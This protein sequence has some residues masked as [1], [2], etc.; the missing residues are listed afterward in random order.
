MKMVSISPAKLAS[1]IYPV[2]RVALAFLVIPALLAAA[3]A[4]PGVR[5]VLAAPLAGNPNGDLEIKP[6]TA[7]NFVVDSNVL[8]P[9]TYAPRSATL[10]AKFC[11]NGS[12]ALTDVVAYIGNYNGGTSSTPGI[13]P[14]RDSS[15]FGGEHDH[16][17]NTGDYFLIH[18][19]GSAGT[20]DATRYIGDLAAGECKTQYWLV[21]YPRKANGVAPDYT[22]DEGN[23]SVT[24]GS[25]KPD[26]DLWLNYDFWA[27]ADDGGSPLKADE[28]IKVTMRNEISAMA[29]KIWPNGDNKVPQ[30]YLDAITDAFGWDTI[31]PS[32]TGNAYPGETVT[33]QG[34]WYDFGVVGFGFDND[35]DLIPDHNAW[36]QPIGDPSSYDPGCFRLVRTYGIVVV[37]RQDGTET[38]IPFEDDLYFENVPDNTG[39]VGLVYYE[40]RALDGACTAGLTPYQEVASGY[41][42]E[43]F[44]GDFGAGIPPLQSQESEVTFDKNGDVTVDENNPITYTL[45]YTNVDPDGAGSMT[46]T[47]GDPDVGLGFTVFE[48]IPDGTYYVLDSADDALVPAG[49]YTIFYSTD[50]DPSDGITWS[51]TQSTGSPNPTTYIKWVRNSEV[52]NGESGS[53]QFQVTVPTGYTATNNTP[54]IENTACIKLGDADCFKED[55]HTTYVNGPNSLSGTVFKDDAGTTGVLANGLQ[56]GDEAGIFGTDGVTVTLYIDTD[57]DDEGDIL[58]GT[59]Q[60]NAS[61]FYQF[62]NL[63]DAKYVVIVNETDGDIPTGYGI[64]TPSQRTADLDSAGATSSAVT[65]T[66]LDFG[67]APALNL[68]KSLQTEGTIYVGDTIEYQINVSNIL[69]G[70]GAGG[71]SCTY[72]LW[73]NLTAAPD[74]TP[75]TGTGNKGFLAPNNV[76]GI[77]DS[78]YAY[79]VMSDSNDY[80]GLSGFNAGDMGGNITSV[81]Y[82]VHV[83]ER[84]ALTPSDSIHIEIYYNNGVISDIQYKGDGTSVPA[85]EPVYF[86]GGTGSSYAITKDI[87]SLRSWTWSD[88]QNNLTELKIISDKGTTNPNGDVNLD[89]A[90]FIIETDGSCGSSSTVLDPVPLT[91][92]FDNTNLQFLS[93]NPIAD[94]VS[95]NTITWG[96]V[97]PLYPG[98]TK[99]VTVKFKA[100]NTVTDSLNTAESANAKYATGIPANTPVNDTA[101][102]TVSAGSLGSIAGVV[103]ND[104]SSPLNGWQG[105]TGYDAPPDTFIENVEVDLYVCQENDGTIITTAGNNTTCAEQSGHWEQSATQYTDNTGAYLFPNLEDGFYRVLVNTSSVVGSL[106]QTGDPDETSGVCVT[107]DSQW[108]AEDVDLEVFE[109]A[110]DY[111]SGGN[112]I[113]NINFGYDAPDGTASTIGDTLFYD[114]NG[115]GIQ[116]SGDEGIKNVDVYLYNLAGTKIA[117]DTTDNIGFYE[118]TGLPAGIYT[119][120]VAT[121][122]TDFPST[123][124]TQTAD[125]DESGSCVTCDSTGTSSVDGTV[126]GSDDTQD[127]GYQ[128]YGKGVIG[129]TVWRDRNGDG[130]QAGTQEVGI[131]NITVSL[132]ADMNG[133]TVWETIATG[134]TDANG[135]YL[136]ENL[137]DANYRVVVDTTDSDLP[138][139][140]FGDRA[141]PTT[142]TTFNVTISG[143]NT[144]LTSDFGFALLGAIGDTI[145]WD[146][147]ADGD[148]DAGEP[149]VN[150]VTVDLYTYT[151]AN[152]NG[153]YDVGETLSG[154]AFR[155][156]TTATDVVT[157]EDGKY[158]FKG[159]PVNNAGE[160]YVVVVDT[161]TGGLSGKTLTSDPSAD[162]FACTELNDPADSGEPSSTVCDSRDGTSVYPG[163]NYMG[164]DFGYLPSGTFGNAVWV[165][166]DN[167]G[168]Y[169]A[170]ENGI[171][172]ITVTAFDGVTTWTTT[173]DVDGY[174]YFSNMPTGN[175]TVTVDTSDSDWPATLPTTPVFD[176]DG[177]LNSNTT[178]I[179]DGSGIVTSVGGH[180]DGNDDSESDPLYLDADFGYR[181]TP[182]TATLSGTICLENTSANGLCGTGDNGVTTLNGEE[183]PYS[184]S[185]VYLYIWDDSLAG[186]GNNDGIVN[187]N[188]ITQIAL[189]TTLANGDYS[190]I[191]LAAGDYVVVIGAPQSHLDLTTELADV[192][193]ETTQLVPTPSGGVDV[194]SAYQVVTVADA[195]TVTNRDFAFESNQ[196]F[197]FGDLPQTY[198][199]TLEG[200]PDGP[201]H[202][203]PATA[204]LYLGNGVDI[205]AN[206]QP[207]SDATGDDTD[208]DGDDDDGISVI[209]NWA[210]GA[211]GG[212]IDITVAGTGYL[213]GW[214]DFN[215]DGDFTDSGERII[216]RSV[217]PGTISN[218]QFDIPAGTFGS[219]A[220]TLNARFRLFDAAPLFP[221]LS[222]FGFAANGEVEDYQ[223]VWGMTVDKDTTTSNISLN[224]TVT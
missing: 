125:P 26:D 13:Y 188:E 150:G 70:D 129:D 137:P 193:P 222:Y 98:Q 57:G 140:V 117:T 204:T 126:V 47:V 215:E 79:S 59:Q 46:V 65:E 185:T 66:D 221:S 127:F 94:S 20:A 32:G 189:A 62:T 130:T 145:F 131:A 211:N 151:D 208:T 67:F 120:K 124:V 80:I 22:F 198:S 115:N 176:P 182:G 95:G 97:G 106:A 165:D 184:G 85:G 135:K 167:N 190:F 36:A 103:W 53:V 200:N 202:V 8:T 78:L 3:L 77:P 191:D 61:G 16:L 58:Y 35:G 192:A 144:D 9:A 69:P 163:T 186:G 157:G 146:S 93:S 51:R 161:S 220:V 203:V 5:E 88:F 199:T 205:D 56:D 118:F 42:N 14:S 173:T 81:K 156:T 21:T 83:G 63:P 33:S 19:G 110:G 201:R 217:T 6:I 187:S 112:A 195:A 183:S 86:D 218:Y 37:K 178:V 224:G 108:Y 28:R 11:N 180:T 153:R 123:Y 107:C 121:S 48:E 159:L 206:G 23:V 214:I 122:D 1:K 175:Y 105:V 52:A 82:V 17:L 143:G 213:I 12:N 100:L 152:S 168:K 155:T 147:N 29:N 113:I 148:Q 128:P 76:L 209:G 55:T 10:G 136:F 89:A 60:T 164:A 31:T 139:D 39:T 43:K 162:G 111:I 216:E 41:D 7:Y 154:S 75:T 27:T 74:G 34:I 24:G 30:E 2:T 166:S 179:V 181:Y 119:V 134:V 169:D 109:T 212:M 149:G 40:Y 96:N 49:D 4:I 142:N 50:T 170:G 102:V 158:L 114:W 99:Q 68:S 73:A 141:T 197:D 71:S 72:N 91:D 25:I 90:G 87:T 104:N 207:T 177:T 132:M 133:D 223:W 210:N 219:G 138:K 172:Y 54:I 194:V 160:G 38:L 116:D 171:A 15:A 92:V 45:S 44:N 101:L 174:Y 196:D 64:S 18:E 84:V